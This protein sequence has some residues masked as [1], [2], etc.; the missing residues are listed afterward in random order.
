L[1]SLTG[2]ETPISLVALPACALAVVAAA[3]SARR[4]PILASLTVFVGLGCVMALAAPMRAVA[5]I[6]GVSAA[7]AVLTALA[8]RHGRPAPS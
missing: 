3:A 6:G 1:V 2:W 4:E 7:G 5:V 8:A